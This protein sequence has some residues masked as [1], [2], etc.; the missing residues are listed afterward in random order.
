MFLFHLL[1]SWPID[2]RLCLQPILAERSANGPQLALAVTL[3]PCDLEL[4]GGPCA[5]G[6][7]MAGVEITIVGSSTWFVPPVC[8]H[9]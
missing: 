1:K 2:H 5:A 3:L 7:G 8:S 4:Y 9:G 6:R